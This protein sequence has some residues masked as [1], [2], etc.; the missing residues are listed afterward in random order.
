MLTK[1]VSTIEEGREKIRQTFENGSALKKFQQMIVGQGV[2]QS[3]ADQ[4]ISDDEEKV[5][6]ILKLSEHQHAAV[7]SRQGF[8]QSI[9]SFKLGTIVQR[10]GKRLVEKEVFSTGVSFSQAAAG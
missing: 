2:S 6:A 7:A 8:V 5:R 9:D 10:L 3:I 1:N 4:L